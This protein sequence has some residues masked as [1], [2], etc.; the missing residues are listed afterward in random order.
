MS[1]YIDRKYLHLISPK[2]ERFAQKK[3]DLYNFRCPICG[4]SK[5][6]K[7]K[8]RGYIY[9][10]GN[11]Y[12]YTC[13]NC[14]IGHTFYNFMKVTDPSLLGQYALERY[15]NGETGNNNYPKPTF[16]EYK[17]S[18]V[19]T[20]TFDLPNMNELDDNHI[21]KQYVI[22]RKIPKEYYSELYYTEDFKKLVASMGIEKKDLMENDV[23]LVIPFYGADKNLV[24]FQGRTLTSSKVKYITIVA[25]ENAPKFF[26]LDRLDTNKRAYILEGPIDSMFIPNSIATADSNLI[27]AKKLNIP[28]M[29][30]VY[31]NEPRNKDLVRQ[32]R[33][34]VKLN[35]N[36]C[37]LPDRILEKDI[38]D[39]ILN[40]KSSDEIVALID[41]FTFSG[42]RAE[43]EFMKWK[44]I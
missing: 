10:K 44:K 43:L 39:Q 41:E 34:A 9:R 33:E 21:A 12:F 28:D 37:L 27:R 19:F 14:G 36:V 35:F 6:N 24:S 31:D 2:L 30:L 1:V 4:D 38:N 13:H 11:D 23:R 26:G 40:G 29:T 15:T 17:S 42:L 16:E 7:S 5:K 20:K 32:I 8:C 3:Q 22:S 18:P 25:N